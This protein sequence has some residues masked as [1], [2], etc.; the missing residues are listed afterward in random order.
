MKK[1]KAGPPHFFLRFFRWYCQPKMLD[2]IE[3]DLME[4]YAR[5]KQKFGKRN[6]DLKF[7]K[8]VLLLF[9]PGVIR[10]RNKNN[11][12]NPIDMFLT[13]LKFSKRVFLKDQFFSLLN[14]LGLAMGIAVSILLLL[15]LQNDLTYD[16]Y[17]VNHERI[18]RLGGHLKATGVDF[19]GART[20]RELGNVL[21]DEFP[22]VQSVVRAVHWGR[23][24]VKHQPNEGDEKAYYEEGIIKSDSTYFSVFT[25]EFISG[26]PQTCLSDLNSLVITESIAKKYFGDENPLDK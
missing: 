17:H 15:I 21:K 23:T 2:Y 19:R 26:N 13:H 16:R 14:I 10:S 6:A 25:H 5:R 4:V 18:Y 1:E 20:A 11:K 22:E 12:P 24:M 7:I 8:D 3:G 9:R